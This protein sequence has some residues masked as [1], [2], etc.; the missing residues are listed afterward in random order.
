MKSYITNGM[1]S[2]TIL[3]FP[4]QY[5]KFLSKL[6]CFILYTYA[7]VFYTHVSQSVMCNP[8]AVK[9]P[10]WCLSEQIHSHYKWITHDT[11]RHLSVKHFSIHINYGTKEFTQKFQVLVRKSS[12]WWLRTLYLCCNFSY[13]D[14]SHICVSLSQYLGKLF[15]FILCTHAKVFCTHVPQSFM[16]NPFAMGVNLFKLQIGSCTINT[17]ECAVNSFSP[18]SIHIGL[19]DTT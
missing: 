14:L 18:A 11:L 3:S 9:E 13:H 7:E 19:L 15:C 8:S 12:K 10:I 5:L 1:V 17:E 2:T 6:F 16:C 4:H